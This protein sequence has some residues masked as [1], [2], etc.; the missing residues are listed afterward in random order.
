MQ[1]RGRVACM[2]Y[3]TVGHPVVSAEITSLSVVTRDDHP[4]LRMQIYN[5]G[6]AH[7]RLAGDVACL[8]GER[9]LCAPGKL[10]DVPVLPGTG[11]WVD[12]EIPEGGLAP[13]ALARITVD[14]ADFGRLIGE[15]ALD[16]VRASLGH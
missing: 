5:T 11:R 3:V 7:F 2:L 13:E 16:P 10:P 12:I 4:C 14:L 15:C 9:A 6:A 1:V 8:I